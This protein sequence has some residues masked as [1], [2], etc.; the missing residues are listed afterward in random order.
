MY[1]DQGDAEGY[2]QEYLNNPLDSSTAYFAEND[3]KPII[4]K[5]EPLEYYA[6][7]DL[8]I[9]EKDRRSYTAMGVAGI[10]PTG[11]LKIVKMYRFRTSDSYEILDNLFEIQQRFNP[12][13]ITIEEE[14]I[15]RSL[16]PVLDKEQRERGI[17][18]TVNKIPVSQD[19]V[20]RARSLQARM[21]SGAIE[22]DMDA[23]WYPALYE[24]LRQFPKGRY[25]DQ[26]DA[27]AHIC[28]SLD[29]MVDSPTREELE[30]EEY[31]E[32]MKNSF[33]FGFEGRSAWT[34][35]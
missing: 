28:L 25:S 30:E 6:G 12:E 11:V 32:D 10:S 17:F 35:Y 5:E 29:K 33:Y 3:F 18:L 23:D 31:E 24:E 1:L 20:K 13:L 9:S 4:N 22:F 2:S 26:V 16:G 15:A 27:L 34:G 8:A 21:R 14:N 7:V 19:K